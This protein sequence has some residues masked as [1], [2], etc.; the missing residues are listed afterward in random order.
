ME[1][2]HDRRFCTAYLYFRPVLAFLTLLHMCLYNNP[3]TYFQTQNT[4]DLPVLAL[5]ATSHEREKNHDHDIVLWGT[6]IT[7]TVVWDRT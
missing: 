1:N 7:Y 5:P 6:H 2:W 3:S 4:S